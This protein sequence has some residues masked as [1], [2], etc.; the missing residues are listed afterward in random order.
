[1]LHCIVWATDA[2]KLNSARDQDFADEVQ[3]LFGCGTQLQELYPTPR[4]LSQR[5]WDG[6]A[7]AARWS[8]ANANV[9]VDT[10]WIG[11]D[12]GSNKVY[13]WASWT[14]RKGILVLR[15]PNDQPGEFK[16]DAGQLFELPEGAPGCFLLRSP[17]EKSQ[18][19]RV[20]EVQ[21]GW[22]HTFLLR[23]FE[24]LVLESESG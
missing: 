19:L 1:M 21:A 16:A 22:P 12:P 23:P 3:S 17:W 10:H 9:L 15:N 11:R 20:L 8:R 24:V 6:L 14:P 5:D 4:L 2:A 18:E 13:G 7:E